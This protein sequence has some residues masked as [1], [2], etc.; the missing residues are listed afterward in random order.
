MRII[1]RKDKIKTFMIF[2]TC[3]I[4]FCKTSYVA[5]PDECYFVLNVMRPF[6]KY[7]DMKTN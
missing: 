5:H 1:I 2:N 7:F 3:F 4:A 6:E